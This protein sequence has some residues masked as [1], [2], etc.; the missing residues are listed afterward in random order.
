M[1]H[2]QIYPGQNPEFS[3]E[4]RWYI[5]L[6]LYFKGL[7]FNDTSRWPNT[8]FTGHTISATWTQTTAYGSTSCAS[9]T[10]THRIELATYAHTS[11]DLRVQVA[12]QTLADLLAVET[13]FLCSLSQCNWKPSIYIPYFVQ[14]TSRVRQTLSR[15]PYGRKIP[16][17][18]NEISSME[19]LVPI[20]C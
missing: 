3:D 13:E 16:C 4:S 9:A 5:L 12:K 14:N 17:V 19:T 11:S 18:L 20:A 1:R 10:R 2:I 6:P 8:L 15:Q 7:S